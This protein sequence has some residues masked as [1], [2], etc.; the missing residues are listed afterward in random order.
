MP[1][2]SYGKMVST[3]DD[4][5]GQ[6][7]G[8]LE[9]LGLR[10]DTLVVFMSDNGHS[11]ERSKIRVDNHSS[12]LP[13]GHDYGANGG[14][15][16][17]GK[18]RGNKGTFFEGGLRVPMIVSF[19]GRLPQGAVRDQA[20]TAADVF[21][22]ILDVCGIEPPEVKFDGASLVPILRDAKAKT[23]HAVMHWQWFDRWVRT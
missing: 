20:V 18:W 22:T 8:K 11:A 19:P 23:H 10:D 7:M 12:G 4:R 16:N 5:I 2:Q 9:Q 6:V 17:T 1:R 3:T 15:G 14:G 21:P 13:K